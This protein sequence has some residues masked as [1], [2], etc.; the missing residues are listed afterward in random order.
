M[1]DKDF[2]F[3]AFVVG[4]ELGQ[5]DACGGESMNNIDLKEAFNLWL[6]EV[7]AEAIM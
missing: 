2:L 4:Y 1:F 3:H 5:D 6:S 7:A